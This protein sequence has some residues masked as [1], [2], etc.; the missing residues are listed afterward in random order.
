MAPTRCAW[1]SGSP[2]MI[3]YHDREWGRP[4]RDDRRLFEMLVLEG[5]Q[6]GLSWSTILSKRE[7][8]QRAFDGFDPATVAG[9][10]EERIAELLADAG[11][12]RNRL[13]IQSAVKNAHAFLKVSDEQGTF[14]RYLWSWVGDQPLDSH[15]RKQSDIPT[16][17]DLSDRL[18][19]DLKA[20]GFNFVGTTIVYSYMQAVGLVNDH[21]E[22]CAARQ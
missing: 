3:A 15:P 12:V 14:A 13:K 19:K 22:S 5:A 11:L 21:L 7:N 4:C 20:K 16:S 17:T 6:A 9:Y 1:A 2:A 10:G 8:Y 18:S